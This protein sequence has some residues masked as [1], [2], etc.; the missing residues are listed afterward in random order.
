MIYC[1]PPTRYKISVIKLYKLPTI[2]R[3]CLFLGENFVL[4]IFNPCC[5][6]KMEDAILYGLEKLIFTELRPNQNVIEGYA[7][8]KD[9]CFAL[10][11]AVGNYLVLK[12]LLLCSVI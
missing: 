8:G 12:L 5:V 11:L 4:I 1:W 7:S 9:V 6:I 3:L 10:R 2:T